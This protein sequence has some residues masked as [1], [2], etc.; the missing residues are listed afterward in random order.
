AAVAVAAPP[1][2]VRDGQRNRRTGQ[3]RRRADVRR[4]C[5]LG[6][7][8]RGCGLEA[9]DAGEQYEQPRSTRGGRGESTHV[10]KIICGPGVP[11]WDPL[12]S[13][14]PDDTLRS[15]VAI[16]NGKSADEPEV[17]A[18]LELL[19]ADHEPTDVRITQ[20]SG[21]ARRFAR[22]SVDAA[23][24]RIIV[25]GGDGTLNQVVTGIASRDAETSFAGVLGIV[26]TGTANDF[27]TCAG[28]PAG[29]PAEAVRALAGYRA[30]TLDLGRVSGAAGAT[31]LNVVTAGFGSE[32]S[33]ETSEELKAV[34][35]RLSYLVAGIASAGEFAPREATIV[36]P[37]FERRLA[38]Y[39]LAIGNARCA[40]G[41]IPVCPEADPTDGLFDVTIIPVGKAGAAAVEI[42]KQGLEGAGD[43]GI[44][45]RAPWLEV[46][47]D[48]GLQVNLDG[49]PASG[50]EFRLEIMPRR[51]KVLL[52]PESP[53][54]ATV[55][56]PTSDRSGQA[57]TGA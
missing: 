6:G 24:D 33:S 18:A 5:G 35:G 27:A 23:V 8:G 31:F 12:P 28:I 43:A 32:V 48:D 15:R 54:R 2:D 46:R 17:E 21:D 45:F 39:L 37:E 55:S 26:P 42:V 4:R 10:D 38:F 36:A 41:G 1:F 52:P 14:M 53:Y 16:V 22:E 49:E 57:P 19:L 34:L 9:D 56:S 7:P 25:F 50:A 30:E 11:P 40:G 51:V 44:R 29:S 20:T 3:E 47:C 13:D